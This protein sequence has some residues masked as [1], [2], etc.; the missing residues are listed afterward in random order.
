MRDMIG[1]QR[2]SCDNERNQ[3]YRHEKDVQENADR[4]NKFSQENYHLYFGH[5]LSFVR[6]NS[7][8]EPSRRQLICQFTSA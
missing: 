6:R 7:R 4:F 2:N 3:E 5:Q 1:S 8:T